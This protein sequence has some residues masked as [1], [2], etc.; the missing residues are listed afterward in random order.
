MDEIDQLYFH[1]M[2]YCF[3]EWFIDI[4]T[5]ITSATTAL[6]DFITFEKWQP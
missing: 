6:Q 3:Y 4:I 1:L 2:Q 5:I